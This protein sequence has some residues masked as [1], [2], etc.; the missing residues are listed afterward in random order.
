MSPIASETRV[1]TERG[2][3]S[4]GR[5]RVS[6]LTTPPRSETAHN[7]S[8]TA[9]RRCKSDEY[10]L[11]GYSQ[12]PVKTGAVAGIRRALLEVDGVALSRSWNRS[13]MLLVPSL[14]S[15]R[16]QPHETNSRSTEK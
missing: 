16:S 4:P 3:R 12:A 8:G 10:L 11:D 5:S 2:F 14:S 7:L 13:D 6:C 9:H 15:P 1:E